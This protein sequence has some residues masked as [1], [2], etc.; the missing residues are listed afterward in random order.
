MQKRPANP[1]RGENGTGTS[2]LDRSLHWLW[3]GSW[4]PFVTASAPTLSDQLLIPELFGHAR[5]AF[6]GDGARHPAQG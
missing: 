1:L 5:G 4:K 6:T 3:S 2:V